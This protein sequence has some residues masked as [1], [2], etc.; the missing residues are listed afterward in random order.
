[1]L[2]DVNDKVAY[3]ATI[4]W[5]MVEKYFPLTPV[6]ITNTDKEWVTPNIKKLILQRQKAHRSENYK[7][8]N[9]LAKRI[10]VEIKKAKKRYNKRK[11]SNLLGS[12][13]KKWYRHINNIIG[14][15]KNSVNFTNIPELANKTS[16]E[17]VAIVNTYFA[18][19]C[20]KYPPL[21]KEEKMEKQ[22]NDKELCGI[23]EQATL[24]LLIKFCK[25]SL[26]PGDLPHKIL[27]E[28][29]PELA[30]PFCDIVNCA[31]ST[32]IFPE[33][34][35][36]AEIVPIPKTN[37]PRALSDLRPISKTP[38]GGKII[39]K[40]LMAELE[41]D[42][43]GKLDLDQYGYTKGSSTTH[44]LIKLTDEAYKSTDVCKA[45]TAVTI[46]Y[47]KAFDYVDHSVLIKKLVLLGVRAEV[48]N[49]IIS[50]LSDRS[51]NT[52]IKGKFSNFLNISCGV[53]QGT[54]GG[55]KLFVILIN[56]VKCDFVKNYKFVDDK[57]LVHSYS[58][59]P[60]TILQ[61]AL[62][63]ETLETVKDKMIINELKWNVINLNY[64][65]KNNVPVNLK[66]NG[67]LI[68]SVSSRWFKVGRK[69]LAYLY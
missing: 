37:P 40:V 27:Q 64:S 1:M 24:K 36:K 29:A 69:Y 6:L 55:P 5:L 3:F 49:L 16:D 38:V 57:T 59:D 63:I 39:E 68:K 67:N 18:N 22:P 33:A 12:S 2:R 25:K 35:K 43:K 9:K 32:G 56:G 48:I 23:T 10:R 26:G 34:Y 28:F 14:N 66:L 31:I 30:I 19:I 4:T 51:H 7:L 50:F 53:P 45:T 15:K 46:D 42:V 11:N 21:K 60:S 17:Q 20:R 54:V 8:R 47:S 58:G 52:K 61:Q 13:S 41:K 62:D 44:Y 65:G